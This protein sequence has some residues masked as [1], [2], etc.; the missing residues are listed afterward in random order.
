[1]AHA[2]GQ[3][4]PVLTVEV[5]VGA[6]LDITQVLDS[7][8][9]DGATIPTC[10]MC[11]FGRPRSAQASAE[12]SPWRHSPRNAEVRQKVLLT[13]DEYAQKAFYE[14]LGYR[15]IRDFGEGT[16]RAFVRFD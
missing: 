7:Y 12:D 5:V 15:E 1:M 16:L 9:S 10:R 3:D 2:G 11:W 14:S 13:D 4:G 6:S 8:D